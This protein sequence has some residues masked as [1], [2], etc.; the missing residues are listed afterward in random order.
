SDTMGTPNNSITSIFFEKQ[1]AQLCAQ[2]AL[3]MLLQKDLFTAVDLAEIAHRLDKEENAVLDAG[4]KESMNMD[5]S[6]FFSVQ[7]IAE[8]LKTFKLELISIL[9]PGVEE[10]KKE[11]LLARAFIC[12]R[13]EHWFVIRKFGEQWFELNSCRTGAILHTNMYVSLFLAQLTNDGYSIFVIDGNL[14]DCV[15]DQVIAANPVT[16]VA[17]KRKEKEEKKDEAKEVQAFS[18]AGARL[19]GPTTRAAA[20]GGATGDDED[21]M[22]EAIRRSLEDQAGPS[23]STRSAFT[24]KYDEDMKRAMELSTEDDSEDR[25]YQMALQM[26]MADLPSSSAAIAPPAQAGAPM[27]AGEEQRAK[28][29]AFLK[30]L[31]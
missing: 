25:S 20:A 11:P 17:P 21:E 29:E 31:E 26:S 12:N 27:T 7:V 24:S 30:S 23:H 19:G 15:A 16:F 1:E 22:Q 14:P 10:I 3:N 5:D 18:G 2:H 8:A 6:G 13:S 9:H 4:H 28:R